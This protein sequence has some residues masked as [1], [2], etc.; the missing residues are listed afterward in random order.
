[1]KL[2]DVL[3]PENVVLDLNA[4]SKGSLLRTLS[5]IA[6]RQ[7]GIGE[8]AIFSAL[9]NREKLGSTGIGEG[10]AIP[11]AAIP[12]MKKP[13]ALF[14]RLSKPIDFEAIDES[15]VDIIAVLL[16]PVEKSSTK[17]NLLA[18]LARILRSEKIKR[19]RSL[20]AASD[21]HETITEAEA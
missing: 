7:L 17:L 19:I 10:I 11:H 12:D 14:V 5:A 2:S 16:V 21:V 13:F 4:S 9:D 15:P 6:A 1:M 20:A 8:A 3:A 18:G